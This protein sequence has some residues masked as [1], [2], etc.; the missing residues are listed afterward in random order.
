MTKAIDNA[1]FKN[2]N[3]KPKI[4]VYLAD[5]LVK[6]YLTIATRNVETAP[7]LNGKYADE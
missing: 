6:I 2:Y 7:Q 5:F 1:A 4:L 3:T